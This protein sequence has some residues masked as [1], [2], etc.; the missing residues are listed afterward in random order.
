MHGS[1]IKIKKIQLLSQHLLLPNPYYQ[2]QLF[3][4]L[5]E[6]SPFYCWY[7]KAILLNMSRIPLKGVWDVLDSFLMKFYVVAWCLM[8]CIY[9]HNGT[10][11]RLNTASDFGVFVQKITISLHTLYITN[12]LHRKLGLLCSNTDTSQK[13]CLPHFVLVSVCGLDVHLLHILCHQAPWNF[14]INY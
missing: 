11:V 13:Q 6:Y 5:L 12:I 8:Y 3:T 1:T 10:D 14:T 9:K 2:C 7:K 4:S